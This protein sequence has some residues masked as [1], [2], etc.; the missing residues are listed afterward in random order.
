MPSGTIDAVENEQNVDG[1]RKSENNKLETLY[2]SRFAR[3]YCADSSA[4]LSRHTFF[5]PKRSALRSFEFPL[6]RVSLKYR[7]IRHKDCRSSLP[8]ERT[9]N[10]ESNNRSQMPRN[11]GVSRGTKI[12]CRC[13]LCWITQ[14]GDLKDYLLES[15]RDFTVHRDGLI[16]VQAL[17]DAK[18]AVSSEKENTPS[19]HRAPLSHDN[20]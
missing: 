2:R 14:E 5:D 4:H 6:L 3:R 15:E 18:I 1:V 10:S 13:G 20:Q 19:V 9:Q 7:L 8:T 16:V 12:L 11:S 17:T